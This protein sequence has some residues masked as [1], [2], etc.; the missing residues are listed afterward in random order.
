MNIL[1]KR[2]FDDWL[3]FIFTAILRALQEA[4]HLWARSPSHIKSA[5]TA[6]NFLPCRP[7]EKYNYIVY[8]L[9]LL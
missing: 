3:A 5:R 7:E 8:K 9:C 6:L 2:S 4:G 1:I